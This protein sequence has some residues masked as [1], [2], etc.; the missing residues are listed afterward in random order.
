V[1]APHPDVDEL[2]DLAEGLLES[3]RAATLETHVHGCTGCAGLLDAVRAV[4]ALLADIPTPPM[5]PEAA[6]RL[7]AVLRA[8]ATRRTEEAGAHAVPPT[9]LA[10]PRPA[11]T[12]SGRLR[13]L[14]AAAAV[15]A[16][17]GGAVS[18]LGSQGSLSTSESAGSGAA[19]DSVQ[20][21]REAAEDKVAGAAGSARP[22]SP[23]A[24]DLAVVARRLQAQQ[25]KAAVQ[26]WPHF[27][28]TAGAVQGLRA[29][30]AAS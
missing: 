16:V 19:E 5:P 30:M 14:A 15:L 21:E 20:M 3:S 7:E 8:E 17:L 11:G 27:T 23:S 9:P 1:N 25:R 13:G 26:E 29:G 4:P 18:L 28:A 2:A 24:S 10:A 22:N 12:W 6:G